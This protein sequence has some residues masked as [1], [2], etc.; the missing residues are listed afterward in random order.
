MK[1]FFMDCVVCGSLDSQPLFPSFF[2]TEVSSAQ[3]VVMCR[4]CGLVYRNPHIPDICADHYDN[5]GSWEGEHVYIERLRHVAEK[6]RSHVTLESGDHFLEIGCGPGW[7]A[8]QLAA[9][10]PQ[11]QPV[12]LEPSINVAKQAQQ[13]VPRA[14]VLP[15]VLKE[16]VLPEGVFSCVVA[17]GVDYLF[18]HHRKDIERMHAL[19][20]DGGIVYIERN[21]FLGQRAL[22]KRP[23]FDADDLFGLN[24]RVN[25]W[26]GREQFVEYLS[27]FFEIVEVYEYVSDVSP[28][29]YDRKNSFVGVVG[30]KRAGGERKRPAIPNRFD[31]HMNILRATAVESTLEDL[32]ILA[33]EGVRRVAICGVGNEARFLA[34]MIRAHNLF[35]IAGFAS[36]PSAG[37]DAERDRLTNQYASGD[38]SQPV[39]AYLVA[40]LLEQD[41]LVSELQAYGCKNILK[42][43]RTGL[44]VVWDDSGTIQ[45]KALLPAYLRES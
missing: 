25:T 30:R 33:R 32:Q 38:P 12:L 36:L 4:D 7:L 41:Q 16:A 9:A 15:G 43:F 28:E 35:S 14:A 22:T 31:E 8:E 34:G 44:P 45:L 5:V 1:S 27:E 39:D 26:F 2:R 19:L 20:R 10:F 37:A 18:Q 42:C 23:M 24:H 11:A 40:S 17:C 21:V 13:R 3:M 6:I 29:P